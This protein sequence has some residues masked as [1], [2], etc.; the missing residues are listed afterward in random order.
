MSAALVVAHLNPFAA[1]APALLLTAW[2]T[3]A[4][5]LVAWCYLRGL[6]R[7]RGHPQGRR[8]QR[9][10]P[11]ALLGGVAVAGAATL[12]PLGEL[13]EGLF[14]THMGQ[15]MVL[16]LVAAPLLAL[17]AP[18]QPLLA[19]MPA[20]L[21]WRVVRT[22]RR[23]P[24]TVL[25]APLVAWLLHVGALWTW[26]LPAAYDAAMRSDVVHVLEHTAFL[27]TAWLFWWHLATASPR[28]LRGPAAM[29]YVAAVVPAGSALGAVITFAGE[30]LYAGQAALATALGV[31]PLLDQRIGGLVMWVPMDLG[32]ILL[33]VLLFRG[34]LQGMERTEAAQWAEAAESPGP[35]EPASAEVRA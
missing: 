30:P 13:A 10:R 12:P 34:W 18:G 33:A 2:A 11:W 3:A 31:D 35:A 6:R 28:R 5:A 29:L 16:V 15:H 9:W 27:A 17:G 19:G 7:M 25:C 21:R 22:L 23:L 32:Y 20:P 26:H 24:L 4:V 14:T 1:G 8:L